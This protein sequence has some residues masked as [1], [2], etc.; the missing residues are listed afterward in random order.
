MALIEIVNWKKPGE[1]LLLDERDIGK[2]PRYVRWEDRDKKP[3]TAKEP[4]QAE[5]EP[6][7]DGQRPETPPIPGLEGAVESIAR[8][9]AKAAARAAKKRKG[10]NLSEGDQ[11]DIK[12][13][14]EHGGEALPHDENQDASGK[15]LDPSGL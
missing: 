4:E 2:D 5:E 12:P 7:K 8:K 15:T 10:A 14:N 3:G 6:A 13:E 9:T 1:F 11:T